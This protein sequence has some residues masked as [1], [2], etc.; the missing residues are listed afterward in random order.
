MRFDPG[1]GE[2]ITEPAENNG[3]AE[4]NAPEPST[5][6]E[7]FPAEETDGHDDGLPESGTGFDFKLWARDAADY[8]GG[9]LGRKIT[10]A[11]FLRMVRK[12][13]APEP[14]AGTDQWSQAEL[15]DALV[16]QARAESSGVD[17][18][19]FARDAADL[20]SEQLGTK[21][22]AVGFRQLVINGQAPA[23]IPGTDRWSQKSVMDWVAREIATAEAAAEN[24]DEAEDG[25][26]E[27]APVHKDVFDFY[28]RTFSLYYELHDTTPNVKT[29]TQPVMAWCRKWWLH[30]GVVGRL[31]AAWYAWEAAHSEGGSAISAWILEH[32][33]RHF[34]RIMAE[35]GPL[36]KCKSEHTEA[37]DVYPAEPVPESL[38]LPDT[39]EEGEVQ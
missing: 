4:E 20:A 18:E 7:D 33:D 11:E 22:T 12:G 8:A 15:E 26:E 39:N 14:V 34:D 27:E 35:D 30:R 17:F 6:S 31:T 23:P 24:G 19:L 38:R 29:R 9:L 13:E 28:E 37:L 25:E 32:A 10:T 3:P 2:L 1:T 21:F 16:A 36:R 5:D